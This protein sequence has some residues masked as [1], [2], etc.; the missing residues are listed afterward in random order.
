MSDIYFN[1]KQIIFEKQ[2]IN[3]QAFT[4]NWLKQNKKD[5]RDVHDTTF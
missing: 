5:H 3:D 4:L 2:S 1:K